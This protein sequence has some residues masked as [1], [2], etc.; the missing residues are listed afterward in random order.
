MS[1]CTW[2]STPKRLDELRKLAGTMT[3]VE[4]AQLFRVS[5]VALAQVASYHG[6]SLKIDRSNLRIVLPVDIAIDLSEEAA[7]RGVHVNALVRQLLTVV[8]QDKLWTAV[9]DSSK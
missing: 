9:L 8:V 2:S 7:A 1:L 4:L 5:R 3:S 6:I